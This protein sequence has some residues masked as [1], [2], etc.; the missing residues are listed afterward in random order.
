MTKKMLAAGGYDFGGGKLQNLADGTSSQDAVTKA[1]MDA[2]VTAAISNLDYKGSV[3]VAST[4]NVSV[5]SAPSTIDGV[6]LAASDRIL[7]KDQ[8]AGAENGIYTFVSA[9]NPLVRATDFDASAEVTAGAWATVEE[10]TANADTEWL[11]T[12]NNPIVLGTTALVFTRF[13]TLGSVSKYT[14]TG[15]GSTGTTWTVT[16]NLG[17]KAVTW[18]V[19]DVADDMF[20]DLAGVATDNNTL[21]LTSVSSLSSGGYRVTVVG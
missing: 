8:S 6:T 9:G 12:T 14:T 18:S 11:L 4:A 19:S 15:P 5:S 16:H 21:T 7:L 3:R 10:G 17:T 1:Q 2:A 13:P 20:L